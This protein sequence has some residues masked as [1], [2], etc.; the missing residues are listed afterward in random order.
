MR[1]KMFCSGMVVGIGIALAGAAP[2]S[3]VIILKSGGEVAPVG[4]PAI[5]TAFRECEF[6]ASTGMLTANSSSIDRARFTSTE[7][8]GLEC[9]TGAWFITGPVVEDRLTEA[10]KF[11]VRTKWAYTTWEAPGAL[12][13]ECAYT[14]KRL[15]G[16]F[17]IPG[18][19]EA[20]VAGRG[21]RRATTPTN[22]PEKLTLTGFEAQLL[23][24]ETEELFE[25][26][27]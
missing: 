3:A 18:P 4:T 7:H 6:V 10:G 12:G 19:T 21:K 9:I 13:T 1:I 25:A 8:I 20:T 24:A 17:T 26:E 27:L 2:A 23:D 22:C 15:H 16:K 14:V 5:G 11:V